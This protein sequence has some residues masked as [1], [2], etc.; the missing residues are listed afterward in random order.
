[1]AS[2]ASRFTRVSG[3]QHRDADVLQQL[4]PRPDAPRVG[5]H[6]RLRRPGGVLVRAVGLHSGKGACDQGEDQ[7]NHCTTEHDPESSDESSLGACPLGRAVLLDR[8]LHP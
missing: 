3:E 5:G 2:T 4:G 1:L 8:G 7:E 6:G